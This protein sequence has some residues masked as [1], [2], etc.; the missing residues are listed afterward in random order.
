MTLVL[1]INATNGFQVI[2]QNSNLS[3]RDV[4]GTTDEVCQSSNA[5][6]RS[7]PLLSLETPEVFTFT[8]AVNN[9]IDIKIKKLMVKKNKNLNLTASSAIY[10]ERLEVAKPP[11]LTLNGNNNITLQ[12]G[13]TY[14]ELGATA[15][16]DVDGNVSVDINGSVDSYRVGRYTIAYTA[17]DSSNNSITQTR[18]VNVKTNI[19]ELKL[20]TENTNFISKYEDFYK[21]YVP[22]RSAIKVIATYNNGKIE[23]VTDKVQWNNSSKDIVFGSDFFQAYIGLFK[24]SASLDGVISNEINI[25]VKDKEVE[26]KKILTTKVVTKGRDTTIYIGLPK[27]PTADIKLKVKI[28]NEDKMACPKTT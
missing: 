3:C 1:S 8:E 24:V 5:L 11:I 20:S 18:I 7:L 2:N 28:K 26:V 19:T 4:N 10:L 15:L 14:T 21:T 9:A 25:E 17:T 12:V 16:D 27:E 13:D 22:A 23:E 6:G